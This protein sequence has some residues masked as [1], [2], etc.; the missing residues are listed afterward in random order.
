M[1]RPVHRTVLSCLGTLLVAAAIGWGPGRALPANDAGSGGFAVAAGAAGV[2][3]AAV[4]APAVERLTTGR[5]DAPVPLAV[6][7][8]FV[9]AAVARRGWP[10][11]ARV[12]GGTRAVALR[13]PRGRAPPLPAGV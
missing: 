11:R 2:L 7:A 1:P 12:G 4:S 10:A 13:R 5:D 3:D 9:L 6:I 8:A